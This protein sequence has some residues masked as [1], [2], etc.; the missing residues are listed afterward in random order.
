MQ[1][2]GSI[3]QA[4]SRLSFAREKYMLLVLLLA[5]IARLSTLS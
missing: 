1:F 3:L 4:E 5:I 2:L